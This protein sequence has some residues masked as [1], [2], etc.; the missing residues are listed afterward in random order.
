MAQLEKELEILPFDLGDHEYCRSTTHGVPNVVEK[1]NIAR[2]NRG[3]HESCQSVNALNQGLASDE[4]KEFSWSVPP[5]LRIVYPRAF[6][7]PSSV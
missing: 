3:A 4:A 6:P 7:S 5:R 2:G 1:V